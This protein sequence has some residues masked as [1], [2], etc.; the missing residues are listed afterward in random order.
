MKQLHDQIVGN[1]IASRPAWARGLKQAKA[2]ILGV[3]R[4]VAPR[5]G[6]WVETVQGS[7][8]R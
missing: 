2:F 6:A 5:V 1:L 4:N 7:P 3:M 8:H